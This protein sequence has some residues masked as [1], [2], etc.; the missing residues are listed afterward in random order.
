MGKKLLALT[1]ASAVGLELLSG[2]GS[3]SSA[4]KPEVTAARCTANGGWEATPANLNMAGIAKRI[5]QGVTA[6]AVRRGIAGQ[7][8]CEPAF[9][10]EDAMNSPVVPVGGLSQLENVPPRMG[11][12]CALIF[13]DTTGGAPRADGMYADFGAVCPDPRIVASPSPVPNATA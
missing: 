2:C 10:G 4:P 6:E 7:V 9:R 13:I 1:A 3:P 11:A 5:G 12:A 8:H